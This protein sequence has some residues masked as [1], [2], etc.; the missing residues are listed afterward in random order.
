[1]VAPVAPHSVPTAARD[2][3]LIVLGFDSRSKVIFIVAVTVV[4][5]RLAARRATLLSIRH[6]AFDIVLY[7]LFQALFSV[8]SLSSPVPS[9]RRYATP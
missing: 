2:R 1:M 4:T 8:L 9:R 3:R 6:S 7:L 5:L